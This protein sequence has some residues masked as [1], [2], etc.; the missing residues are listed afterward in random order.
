MES[1]VFLLTLLEG[2]TLWQQSVGVSDAEDAEYFPVSGGVDCCPEGARRCEVGDE[3]PWPYEG[4]WYAQAED[5]RHQFVTIGQG[6]VV[7]YFCRNYF[8]P[9]PHLRVRPPEQR[10]RQVMKLPEP[11]PEETDCFFTRSAQVCVFR[12]GENNEFIEAI[13]LQEDLLA[14]PQGRGE[15][16][17]VYAQ[18]RNE[19][20]K[21]QCQRA[22]HLSVNYKQRLYDAATAYSE[23]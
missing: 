3:M 13:D 18:S 6:G 19:V 8:D 16:Y 11:Y 23:L 14:C 20:K 5:G 12:N 7:S 9:K 1:F 15:P 17:I 22:E 4:I 2:C 10:G 21:L